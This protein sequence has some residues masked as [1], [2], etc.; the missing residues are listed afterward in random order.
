MKRYF[1]L[2]LCVI[3]SYVYACEHQNALQGSLSERPAS[4][5]S[6]YSDESLGD[7]P[8]V[9]VTADPEAFLSQDHGDEV[10]IYEG[11]SSECGLSVATLAKY[12]S[13]EKDKQE[14]NVIKKMN[15]A[16]QFLGAP[17]PMER[18][19][20]CYTF[21]SNNVEL[22]TAVKQKVEKAFSN[23]EKAGKAAVIDE[24]NGKMAELINQASK[25]SELRVLGSINRGAELRISGA[26]LNEEALITAI[27]TLKNSKLKPSSSNDAQ[28]EHVPVVPQQMWTGYDVAGAGAVGVVATIVVLKSGYIPGFR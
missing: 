10:F 25:A 19:D 14:K 7:L 6:G 28:R 17:E 22:K 3:S 23:G 9:P 21:F 13:D 27:N 1:V 26:Y 11:S 12:V 24:G 16:A 4:A 18:L 20:Q 15:E 2:L 5:H 8:L